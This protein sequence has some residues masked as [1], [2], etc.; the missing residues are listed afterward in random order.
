MRLDLSTFSRNMTSLVTR[1]P[2]DDGDDDAWLYLDGVPLVE[3]LGAEEL[4]VDVAR[5]ATA[6][7]QRRTA[8]VQTARSQIASEISQQKP[9][10]MYEAETVM[11]DSAPS[12]H[13]YNQPASTCT[14]S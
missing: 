12:S 11:Y 8:V 2:D 14:R 9:R 6:A 5:R 1:E 4:S 13:M 3:M 10:N 7:V